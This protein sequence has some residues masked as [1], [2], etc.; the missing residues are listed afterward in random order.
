ME[1]L[2]IGNGFDLAHGL[3][4]KYGDFLK[5]CRQ[6]LECPQVV[7]ECF[8]RAFD[9]SLEQHFK[10]LTDSMPP[11]SILAEPIFLSCSIRDR[12][13]TYH[14]I[15]WDLGLFARPLLQERF[16]V[17]SNLCDNLTSEHLQTAQDF[18][19]LITGNIWLC[20]FENCPT[21][22]GD[23]WIDFESEISRVIRAL[24]P[25]EDFPKRDEILSQLQHAAISVS[26]SPHIEFSRA[27]IDKSAAYL[28]KDLERLIRALE[29]YLSICVNEA[30]VPALNPDIAAIAPG[31]THILSF[32]YSNTFQRLYDPDQERAYCYIHGKANQEGDVDTCN[33]VLGIDDY[34]G[35]TRKSVDLE[36]LP[37]K[38]YYQRI[39]KSTDNDYLKWVDVIQNTDTTHNLSV[40]GHS[41]DVTDRDVLSLLIQNDNV[42][43]K[44]YYHREHEHDKKK[45]GQYIKNLVRILGPD[46]LI[47]K[48]GGPKPTIEFVPQSTT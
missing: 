42:H 25:K 24:D 18:L 47:R 37:F 8:D 7:G 30:S 38:K 6:G 28:L 14:Q 20:Y 41:L 9:A 36:L 43:T 29:I 35:D 48:T 46:E 45:L 27:F 23:L 39:Y 4:T 21:Y 12:I 17:F 11:L 40:F 19:D 3:P 22:L 5:F 13:L 15:C 2:L 10:D 32:N 34:L 16:Q 1:I 31:L 44:I 33:L 26:T